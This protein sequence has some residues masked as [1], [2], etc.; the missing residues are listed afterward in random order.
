MRSNKGFTLIEL[1]AVIVVLAIIA[2]IATPMVLNTIND[3]KKG[4]LEQSANSVIQAVENKIALSMLKD[5]NY[6]ATS[7]WTDK[8]LEIKGDKPVCVNLTI[9]NGVVT[10]GTV[11]FATGTVTIADGK[12]VTTGD[13]ATKLETNASDATCTA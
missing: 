7:P 9:A 8:N 2:L 10:S 3:A 6:V 13:N 4:A 1:L 5:S 11:K 12:V